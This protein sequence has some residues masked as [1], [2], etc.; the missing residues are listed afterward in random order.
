MAAAS[1]DTSTMVEFPLS[2]HM[3]WDSV[4]ARLVRVPPGHRS[5]K[6]ATM[7]VPRRSTTRRGHPRWMSLALAAATV[8][9][10]LAAVAVPAGAT[11]SAPLPGI[12]RP[13]AVQAGA[14]WL[15][16]QLNASGF[17]PTT[18]G[19]SQ[20]DLS[21]TV[22]TVLALSA[23]DADLAQ[24]RRGLG[25]MA[26]N[27]DAYVSMA[28][29]D[30][31]GQLA[32][33][34]LAAEAL[35]ADPRS[36]GGT[37]LVARLLA[38]QQ[39]TGADAGLF[40]TSAQVTDYAAG[41]Y[42]QGLALAALAA[43][44]VRGTS[45]ISAATAWLVAAQCPSGGWTTPDNSVNPCD[46]LPSAYAGPDTNSTALAVE[47]LAAQGALGTAVAAAA[48]S[49]LEHGQDA[50]AGWS[51]FPNTAATPGV[52]DPDSTALVLQ[53][54]GALGLSSASPVLD[55]GSA[56]PATALAAFQLTGGADAGAFTYPGAPSTGNLLATYQAVPALA[57][58]SFPWGP[59]GG[60]YQEVAS[61]GGVFAFGDA[62]YHGSMGGTR[63]NAPVVGMASTPDGAGYWLVA[64]DG[65]V[66][67]FGDATYHGS[68][69]GTRLNA[70]I[71]GMAP[72]P[73]G[74]GY[75]L[76]AADGGVFAFGDATYHGSM[77][78]THLDQ[79]VVGMTRGLARP[80][81]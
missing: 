53:A 27:V 39:T 22:Q 47:G 1:R 57:G 36:F 49:F 77:G 76:V 35:G 38:T 40:G 46:G 10:A 44:G 8:P 30:G 56:T 32:L 5:G 16:G 18:P 24:A 14:A 11:T 48:A 21:D 65:G 29:S 52:T 23:A 72:T 50:D 51:Y 3:G 58:L 31:P 61:D 69:G 80:V 42:Q 45:Q 62:T 55:R 13:A 59:A 68:T 9:L 70:P 67:T 74:A 64:A 73:D 43:A 12:P 26:A 75:W 60:G 81:G 2:R 79:P 4:V 78:G 66:F 63:L 54:L 15:A 28:G 34:I 37:D 25:V 7:N 33:L 19:G 20:P 71:V 17:I 6:R 41:G